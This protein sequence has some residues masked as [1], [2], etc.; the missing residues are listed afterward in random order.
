L[1]GLAFNDAEVVEHA[2]TEGLLND[3]ILTLGRGRWRGLGEDSAEGQSE[4]K[5][6]GTGV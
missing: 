6:E 5:R 4:E 3:S 2:E 1:R